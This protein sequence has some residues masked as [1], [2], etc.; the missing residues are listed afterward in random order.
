MNILKNILYIK[1]AIISLLS[2]SSGANAQYIKVKDAAFAKYLCDS[3]PH[4]MSPDCLELDTVMA[5]TV[6]SRIYAIEKGIYDISELRY[7]ENIERAIFDRNN[8][9]KLPDLSNIPKLKYISF[10]T[11]NFSDTLDISAYTNLQIVVFNENKLTHIKGLETLPL[12]R[13]I[14]LNTNL[15]TDFPDISNNDNLTLVLLRYNKLTYEDILPLTKQINYKSIFQVFPQLPITFNDSTI[16]TALEEE[17]TINSD[18]DKDIDGLTYEWYHK[19][20]MVKSSS[21]NFITISEIQKSDEGKY[22]AY[23]KSDNPLLAND[24]IIDRGYFVYVYDCPKTVLY[25]IEE[26]KLCDKITITPTLNDEYSRLLE[27]QLE[28]TFTNEITT[29][30]FGE[31]T[32]IPRGEYKI[33]ATDGECTVL[34][35][36]SRQFNY[37]EDCTQHFTPNGDGINDNWYIDHDGTVR[38]IN[39]QGV[40]IKTLQCPAEWDGT[41]KNKTLAPDGKYVII[42]SDGTTMPITLFK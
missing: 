5:K 6:T 34:L 27:F 33:T 35:E 18:V 21:E 30:A 41:T 26:E 12:L 39:S 13:D 28:N 14:Q 37:K 9:S 40:T 7:F 22:Y 10:N 15:F 31:T 42:Y 3:F 29:I 32:S 24:S 16:V 36:A 23:V 20:V 1:I 8:I 17:V 38:I 25:S 2:F 4:I 19:N 11:N